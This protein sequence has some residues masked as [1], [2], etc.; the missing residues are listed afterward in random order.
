MNELISNETWQN[1][2]HVA[3]SSDA[4]SVDEDQFIGPKAAEIRRLKKAIEFLQYQQVSALER[5][6]RKSDDLQDTNNNT[7]IPMLAKLAR[8]VKQVTMTILYLK[9]MPTTVLN[10]ETNKGSGNNGLGA[11]STTSIAGQVGQVGE[12]EDSSKYSS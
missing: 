9:T 5:D 1:L 10:E 8:W 3:S 12:D 4:V 2:S 7:M 6:G 11:K